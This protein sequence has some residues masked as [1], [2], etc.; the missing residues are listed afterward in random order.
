MFGQDQPVPSS[1]AASPGLLGEE[2]PGFLYPDPQ[3]E[4][5]RLGE[6]ALGALRGQTQHCEGSTGSEMR[7][8][9]FE[10]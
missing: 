7:K 9:S 4:G 8:V 10:S 1:T 2:G 6:S 3:K 5:D